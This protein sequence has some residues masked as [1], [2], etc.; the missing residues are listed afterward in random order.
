MVAEHEPHL[1]VIGAGGE[2]DSG[3]T[4]P[5]LGG[6][7]L[8]L[9]TRFEQ[10]LLLVRD[11]TAAVYTTSLIALD[12]ASA[13][14]RRIVLWGSGL[15][16][17]GDCHVVHAY[18][19]PYVERMRLR[20]VTEA[21]IDGRMRQAHEEATTTVLEVLGAAEGAAR[22][23]GHAV[24]GEP[25]ATVL[26]EIMRHAPQLVVIGKRGPRAPP[27]Q[28]GVMGSVGFRIAYHTPVDVLIIS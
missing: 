15:V 4:G 17:G 19:L 11:A 7:A 13:L 26:A 20:G 23:Q 25:V 5:C 16:Q 27:A 2:H 6:T 10:P 24:R 12:T 3:E 1:V 18:D 28:H 14:S 9:L 21:V 22:V 8:K